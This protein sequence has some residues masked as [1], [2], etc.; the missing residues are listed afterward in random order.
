MRRVWRR[1]AAAAL[2]LFALGPAPAAAFDL[3]ATHEVTVQFAFPDGKPMA[4]APVRVF[5]PGKPDKPVLTGRAD[6]RGK[7]AFSADRN[8][9]WSAEARSG[10][11]IARVTIRVG[12][13][14]QRQD[15]PISPYWIW[16][17]LLLI[18]VIAFGYRILRARARRPK[19]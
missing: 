9:F 2:F 12:G 18:L 8:G 13:E 6:R 16:G 7:F 14:E 19:G 15:K 1:A 17:G 5:A 4:A 3:F 10:K 11:E